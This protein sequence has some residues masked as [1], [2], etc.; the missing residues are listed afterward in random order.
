MIWMIAIYLIVSVVNLV[1]G[2]YKDNAFCSAIGGLFL[3]AA[4]CLMVCHTRFDTPTAMDVYQGKTTLE[5]TYKDCVAIDS[6][7]VYKDKKE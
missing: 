1:I 2:A 5:I 6:V 4:I 3:G 7:V